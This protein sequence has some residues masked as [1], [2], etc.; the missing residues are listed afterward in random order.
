MWPAGGR[1]WRT[2]GILLVAAI[3]ANSARDPR[4]LCVSTLH[5]AI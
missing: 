1:P 2:H 5:T 3:S 4:A